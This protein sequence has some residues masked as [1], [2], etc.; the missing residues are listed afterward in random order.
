MPGTGHRPPQ[1]SEEYLPLPSISYLRSNPPP[2]HGSNES[3]SSSA[4]SAP[5][6][7][8]G[9]HSSR[10]SGQEGK[11]RV[12]HPPHGVKGPS[13]G[14][15]PTVHRHPPQSKNYERPRNA[16]IIS[17]GQFVFVSDPRGCRDLLQ[18]NWSKHYEGVCERRQVGR[19][20]RKQNDLAFVHFID[21]RGY[22]M[23]LTFPS[24]VL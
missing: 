5:S 6:R 1:S 15:S 13:R 7:P 8:F 14:P 18:G 24:G 2:A 10:P 9:R 21:E 20:V 11:H 3:T 17:V 4:P 12:P 23:G 22:A 19:V 16:P